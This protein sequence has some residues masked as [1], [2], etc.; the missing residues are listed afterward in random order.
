MGAKAI[1]Y[2]RTR[3]LPAALTFADLEAGDGSLGFVING[4]GRLASGNGDGLP[5]VNGDGYDDLGFDEA[6]FDP[7]D[8]FSVGRAFILY[9]KRARVAV[10]LEGPQARLLVCANRDTQTTV[11][12]QLNGTAADCELAGLEVASG[13]TVIARVVATLE[14]EA[15]PVGGNVARAGAVSAVLCE[16]ISQC[17]R[18]AAPLSADGEFDCLRADLVVARGDV[19]TVRAEVVVN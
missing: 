8:E 4:I 17:G 2:G 18:V 7:P 5:D 9:G 1:L 10:T 11:R 19:V 16:N 3:P 15:D 6:F 14:N 12:Q 13:D